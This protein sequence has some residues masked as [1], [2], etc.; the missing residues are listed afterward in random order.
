MVSLAT[1]IESVP[2]VS[3]KIV[4]ALKHLGIKNIR[5]LLL[6]LPT[7]YDDFSHIKKIKH[8]VVDEIVTLQVTVKRI[9]ARRTARRGLVIVE[10]LVEDDT[11]SLRSLWFN[12]P[13]IARN[14]KAGDR[15][16]LSGRISLGKDGKYIQNPAYEKI[17]RNQPRREV[18]VPTSLSKE[19]HEASG[20]PVTGIHT[21]GLIAVYPETRGITSRW[22]RFLVNMFI[23]EREK[24]ADTLSQ[25]TRRKYQLPELKD[26]VLSLHTPKTLA[27]AERAR[28]RFLFEELLLIQM[29]SLQSRMHLKSFQAPTIPLDVALIKS[30]V[31]SLPFELT[32]AQRR[33]MW[34]IFQDIAKPRPMNRLLEGDVG[35][36]KTVVASAASL[37]AVRSGFRVLLMAPTE[38]LA[39]QHF[40]TFQKTLAPFSLSVGLL[41]GSVKKF[42][43]DADIVIGTHALIHPV[44]NKPLQAAATVPPLAEERIS[45]GVK[46]GVTFENLGLVIIDEQHRFG[47]QQRAK[48]VTSNQLP[49]TK[50][51]PHF[52]SMTATPIPRTLALSIYGDLDLSVLDEMPKSRKEIIT[53]IVEPGKREEAYEFIRGE[54]KKGRQAFV[55]CPRIEVSLQYE[56]SETS[57]RPEQQKFLLAEVKAVKEEYRKLSEEIFPDFRVGMLHGKLKSKEKDAVMKKF[58]N[59]EVDI[60]VSTS[61]IEVGVDVPNAAI[62]LIEGAERFGLAQLHQFR[63]RVGRGSEQSYCFLFPTE[64]GV[65]GRRLRAIVDAKTGFELAEKDLEIRGAGDLLGTRQSGLSSFALAA[66]TD[67]KLVREVRREAA[68]ILTKDPTLSSLPALRE[69]LELLRKSVHSE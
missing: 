17:T 51:L 2:K 62:M 52:L 19:S 20:L 14:I 26:A 61:V 37:L 23:G 41:T 5:D 1:S 30:F 69:K 38:I 34:E 46:K 40:E 39:R 32:N 68:E 9:A 49:V 64:D 29:R 65:V 48:L 22:I 3:K 67:P 54:V 59:K 47:V 55:I 25:E 28:R 53:K 4:P 56:G 60:L 58:K 16:N 15:I 57:I 42:H 10:A 33:S 13:F 24:L 8:I 36:G 45:N 43:S 18:G 66:V 27:E 44:R 7:R 12:Q 6:Y 35:S 63:G 31:Q 50:T 21:G 11:G